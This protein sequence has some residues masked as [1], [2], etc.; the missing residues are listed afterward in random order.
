M[1]QMYGEKTEEAKELKLDTWDT[2]AMYGQQISL[3]KFRMHLIYIIYAVGCTMLNETSSYRG[4]I[5]K[6]RSE[7][8][9]NQSSQ[10]LAVFF[11]CKTAR[12]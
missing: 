3:L 2:K 12:G 4:N 10:C 1:L 6:V 11:A 8:L 9:R 5:N 7:S